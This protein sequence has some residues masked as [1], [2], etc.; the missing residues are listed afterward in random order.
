MIR[1]EYILRII[2]EFF[3]VLSRINAL[4]QGLK[5]QEAA[6]QLDEEF[7]RLV[8]SG[9][10]TA[11]KL[12]DTELLA[13]IIQ[14]E[15]TQV[16]HAKTLMLSNLLKEA[17]DIAAGQDRAEESRSCYLKGL[18][19]LLESLAQGEIEDWPDLTPKVEAFV[20][21]LSDTPLPCRL[22]PC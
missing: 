20:A 18:H 15:P 2:E 19:L 8:G 5:W 12:T 16:V 10:E 4:K 11:A 1:R 21:A 14:G 22:K 9:A 17:G 3:E 13:R 6:S 7:Q